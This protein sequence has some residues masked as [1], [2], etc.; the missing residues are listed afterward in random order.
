MKAAV[1]REIGKPLSIEDVTINKP[2]PHEVLVRTMAAG[3][4]HSDLHFL[5]GH[6]KTPLPVVLGHESAGV[7][8]AVGAEVRTVKPGDHVV[9]CL[10]AFCG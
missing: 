3:V 10:S 6:Y 9:T 4:C 1:L 5:E 2:G 7:V 8:E